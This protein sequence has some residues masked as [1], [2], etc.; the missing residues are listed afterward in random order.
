MPVMAL[1]PSLT[2]N[3][4]GFHANGGT[5]PTF[6]LDPW[7]SDNSQFYV[8]E[9]AAT[10]TGTSYAQIAKIDPTSGSPTILNDNLVYYSWDFGYVTK[11]GVNSEQICRA[12]NLSSGSKGSLR[13]NSTGTLSLYDA[14]NVLVGT[15]ATVLLANTWYRL[16]L[17][18]GKETGAA[19]NDA[20]YEV[21]LNGSTIFSG[22][23]N[24]HETTNISLRLG[25]PQN[26]SSQTVD[27]LYRN[28]R[29]STDGFPNYLSH[30]K[31][32]LP[33]GAGT[34]SNA[35]VG[36]WDSVNDLPHNDDTD[37]LGFT[38]NTGKHSARLQTC[39]SRGISG[40]I[41][42]IMPFAFGKD[43]DAGLTTGRGFIRSGGSDFTC[44]NSGRDL[45]NTEY[46]V[47]A[48][49]IFETD[50]SDELPWTTQKLDALEVGCYLGSSIAT[51]HRVTLMG[52]I[53]EYL[54]SASSS[55]SKLL[56]GATGRIIG[57]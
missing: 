40:T 55:R 20:P 49:K 56:S 45:S 46:R 41:L 38:N 48:N 28:M 6:R 13:I 7:D 3:L 33:S 32:L 19:N 14:A 39:S 10:T 44:D 18:L 15:D 29:V 27:F 54:P 25:K 21:K 51:E 53:V 57:G 1:G 23:G 35:N 47:F 17:S 30:Q 11:P 31:V 8:L 5:S 16:D 43:T 34:Y 24:F 52:V 12:M 37:Y 4:Q 26:S 42:S 2:A 9:T 22:V 36:T 50:P